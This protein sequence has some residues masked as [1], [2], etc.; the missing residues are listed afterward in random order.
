MKIILLLLLLIP[1][2][3]HA[4]L[5][6]LQITNASNGAQLVFNAYTRALRALP[7]SWGC[8][9]S[10]KIGIYVYTNTGESAYAVYGSSSNQCSGDHV[11][12]SDMPYAYGAV[13]NSLCLDQGYCND[14]PW[15]KGTS[16]ATSDC[17]IYRAFDRNNNPVFSNTCGTS[18]KP[19]CIV[20][21][22]GWTANNFYDKNTSGLKFP[23]DNYFTMFFKYWPNCVVSTPME[24]TA[25]WVQKP[26]TSVAT[27]MAEVRSA[28]IAA[29]EIQ[30]IPPEINNY[31]PGFTGDNSIYAS[32][33]SHIDNGILVSSGVP[34]LYSTPPD[35]QVYEQSLSTTIVNVTVNVSTAEIVNEIS[36]LNDFISRGESPEVS[37]YDY[38]SI[39]NPMVAASTPALVN[40]MQT[41][42]S[43]S[44]LSI[45]DKFTVEES[46]QP[47]LPCVTFRFDFLNFTQEFCPEEIT[48]F[49]NVISVLYALFQI[50]CFMYSVRILY[51][52]D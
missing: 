37:T 2:F 52:G 24:S 18:F 47:M 50:A 26:N 16:H 36:E 51:K 42:S 32:A 43:S 22:S 44:F 28:I 10:K 14:V 17:V 29:S 39:V 31:T 15:T 40:F 13:R 23:Y 41:I 27:S 35:S 3:S 4:Q 34:Q 7:S 8:F 33:I 45:L 11:S 20:Y 21:A 38:A 30:H 5:T 49:S 6:P 25:F 12:Y 19:S 48:G 1:S 9:V 46:T